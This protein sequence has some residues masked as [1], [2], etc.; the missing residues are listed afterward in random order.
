MPQVSHKP[1]FKFLQLAKKT[2]Q[3]KKQLLQYVSLFRLDQAWYN[4]GPNLCPTPGSDSFWEGGRGT[5]SSLS[6]PWGVGG[7]RERERERDSSV[8]AVWRIIWPAF[9]DCCHL[10][11]RTHFGVFFKIWNLCVVSETYTVICDVINHFN[12]YRD[13]LA[14]KTSCHSPQRTV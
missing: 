3:N 8:G 12:N 5:I 7:E 4:F 6:K 11:N 9:L 1:S 10:Y 14:I 2:K 13:E